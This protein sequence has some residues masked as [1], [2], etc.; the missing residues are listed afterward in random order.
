MHKASHIH[1]G[2]LIQAIILLSQAELMT[3]TSR[4]DNF[5]VAL[6]FPLTKLKPNVCSKFKRQIHK[7]KSFHR[8]I[9]KLVMIIARIK[10]K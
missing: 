7:I 2:V 10:V 4:E 9:Q 3:C 8:H 1:N 6:G 5:F